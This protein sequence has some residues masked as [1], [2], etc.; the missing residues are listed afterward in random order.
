MKKIIILY[1]A[2]QIHNAIKQRNRICSEMGRH[3]VGQISILFKLI[4]KFNK[5]T[6]Q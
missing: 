4:Q 1:S 2:T 3:N 5:M 6:T